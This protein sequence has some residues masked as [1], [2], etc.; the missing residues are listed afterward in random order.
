MPITRDMAVVFR[1]AAGPR[2]GFGHL[3]RCRA[4][5]AALGIRPR[6]SIRG[7]AATRRAAS[8][9]AVEVIGGARALTA[10]RPDVVVVDDPHAGSARR[11]TALA[12]RY[13]CKVAAI[14]DSGQ[15]RLPADLVID[16]RICAA[17]TSRR[18]PTLHGPR[19]A[20]VDARIAGLRTGVTTA[21][22]RVVVALGGGRHVRQHVARVVAALAAALPQA[23]IRVAPGFTDGALPALPAG[24]WIAPDALAPTL[25]T[26]A[27]AVV[28]GGV[29]LYEALALGVPTLGVAVVAPQRRTVRQ[30]AAMGAVVDAGP[31]QQPG[32]PARLATLAAGVAASPTLS[33]RLARRGRRLIDGVGT[34]RIAEAIARLGHR[35]GRHA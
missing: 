10:L 9:L 5:A 16:G 31:V 20:V 26:A 32:L 17:A 8:R 6:M 2:L 35:G 28:A 21:P 19:F 12:R 7:T 25:A 11:W 14:A 23:D 29:T 33:R 34:Q 27:L 1:V 13:G 24:R 15:G 3:A 22:H 30:L 4:I 18:T